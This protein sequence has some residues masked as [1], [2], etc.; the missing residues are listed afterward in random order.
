MHKTFYCMNCHHERPLEL[1]SKWRGQTRCEPC[2]DKAAK[3]DAVRLFK[4]ALV[5][6]VA[7]WR[8]GETNE[9]G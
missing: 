6:A 5:K 4:A 7:P 8:N 2:V 9:R 1:K 3:A